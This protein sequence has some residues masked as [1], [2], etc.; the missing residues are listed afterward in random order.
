MPAG[1]TLSPEHAGRTEG[2]DAE[3]RA[4][5][6]AIGMG[7]GSSIA[8]L[9][10][11]LMPPPAPGGAEA[12]GELRELDLDHEGPPDGLSLLACVAAHRAYVRGRGRPDALSVGALPIARLMVWAH[13]ATLLGA[14][15]RLVWVGPA[16]R[17]PEA[18]PQQM[19]LRARCA[20]AVDGSVRRAEAAALV[21]GPEQQSSAG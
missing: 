18:G 6:D 4:A 13:R 19:V 3:L 12:M 2:L 7:L 5:A 15:P 16:I 14:A 9:A 20:V 21:A 8:E 11:A 10:P 1:L 17:A